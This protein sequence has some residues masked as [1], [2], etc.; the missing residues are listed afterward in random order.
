MG[1][2]PSLCGVVTSVPQA[3]QEGVASGGILQK[4]P[5]KHRSPFTAGMVPIEIHPT[6]LN[7]QLQSIKCNFAVL[8]P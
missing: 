2:A 4:R 7:D 8:G 5:Q 3:C 1:S 6:L